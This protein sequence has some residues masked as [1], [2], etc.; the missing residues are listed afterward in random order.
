MELNLQFKTIKNNMIYLIGFVISLIIIN[1]FCIRRLDK[2]REVLSNKLERSIK[3]TKG[4][5]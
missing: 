5:K 4:K 2:Q 1:I 3:Q